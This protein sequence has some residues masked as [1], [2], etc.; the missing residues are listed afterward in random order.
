M[1]LISNRNT[2]KIIIRF[3]ILPGGPGLGPGGPLAGGPIH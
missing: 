3:I 1:N 2:F